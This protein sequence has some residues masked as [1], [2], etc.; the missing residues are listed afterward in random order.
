M[1]HKKKSEV[2]K[3]NAT[4]VFLSDEWVGGVL[5]GKNDAMVVPKQFFT[6]KQLQVYDKYTKNSVRRNIYR[7]GTELFVCN[8]NFPVLRLNLSK[9]EQWRPFFKRCAHNSGRSAI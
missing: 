9:H 5:L 4:T 3:A 2:T 7:Y 6:C 1:P 8:H